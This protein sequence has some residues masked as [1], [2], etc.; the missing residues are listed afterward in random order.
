[1][2]APDGTVYPMSGK[3]EELDRPSRIVFGSTPL[4][5][6]GNVLFAMRTTVMLTDLGGKTALRLE[7][8]VLDMASPLAPQ[9]LSGMEQGWGQ[10]LDRLSALVTKF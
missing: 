5:A 1:M 3:Y 9:F 7:A 2:R 6:E 10:S 4:D 8:K